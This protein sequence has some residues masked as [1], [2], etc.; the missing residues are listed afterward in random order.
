MDNQHNKPADLAAINA[1]LAESRGPQ[2]WRSLEDWRRRRSSGRSWK[3]SSHNRLAR[4]RC[5]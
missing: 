5:R 3:M 1:K 4:C 2:Y